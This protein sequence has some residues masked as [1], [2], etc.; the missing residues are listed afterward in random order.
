MKIYFALPERSKRRK[1]KTGKVKDKTGGAPT[2]TMV[3]SVW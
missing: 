3:R 1:K 2:P